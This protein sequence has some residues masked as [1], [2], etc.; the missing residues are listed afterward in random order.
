LSGFVYLCESFKERHNGNAFLHSLIHLSRYWGSLWKAPVLTHQLR[1]WV[2]DREGGP[3][4]Q[5][6]LQAIIATTTSGSTP[7]LGWEQVDAAQFTTNEDI[8]NAVVDEQ[9]WI[10]VVGVFS[11][12]ITLPEQP[13]EL[14]PVEPNAS[15]NLAVARQTG[16]TSYSATSAISVYYAQGRNEIA[17]GNYILPIVQPLLGRILGQFNTKSVAEYIT[18]NSGNATALQLLSRAP[19]TLSQP[20]WYTMSNVRPYTAQVASAITL[21]G[22]IYVIIFAYAPLPLQNTHPCAHRV[23]R[24]FVSMSSAGA[25]E[26]IGPYLNTASLIRLRIISPLLIYLP[27]SLIYGMISLPFKIP[28]DAKYS[29]AGGFFLFVTMVYVGMAALGLACEAMITILGPRFMTF[30]LLPL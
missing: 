22:H 10:A 13:N 1:A 8:I 18:A 25:R 29:Y 9:T 5:A 17:V 4:G 7:V 26:I 11:Q 19:Q 15:N 27:V 16:D 30:F 28:F 23:S 20:I 21:V 24:F 6:V 14:V 3:L 2:I 12:P